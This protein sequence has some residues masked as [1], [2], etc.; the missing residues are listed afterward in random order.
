[1]IITP[2]MYLDKGFH[3]PAFNESLRAEAVASLDSV[4]YVAINKRPIFL[5]D[6]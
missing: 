2:D 3:R 5:S 6:V 1:M 4:D